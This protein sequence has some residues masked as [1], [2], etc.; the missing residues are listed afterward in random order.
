MTALVANTFNWT[1][2]SD[3]FKNYKRKLAKHKAYRETVAELS[4]LS[5]AEL[6][7][8]GLHR[9]DIHSIAMETHYDNLDKIEYNKNLKGWI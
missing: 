8:I 2:V 4:K 6:R 5:D 3:W 1:A 7:D 9:G